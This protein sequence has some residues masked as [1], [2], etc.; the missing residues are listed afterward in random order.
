MAGRFHHNGKQARENRSAFNK[1]KGRFVEAARK[2]IRQPV[3]LLMVGDQLFFTH[4]IINIG[5]P[6]SVC[7]CIKSYPA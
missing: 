5:S 1:K 6:F 4:R 2:I 3:I 7:S